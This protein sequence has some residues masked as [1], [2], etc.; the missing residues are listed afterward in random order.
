MAK[1][2][3]NKGEKINHECIE[4]ARKSLNLF[5]EDELH[6][7]VRK[8]SNRTREMELSNRTP[9]LQEA[10]Q[11]VNRSEM[12]FLMTS[13][14]YAANNARKFDLLKNRIKEGSNIYNFLHKVGKSSDYNI[15]NAQRDAMRNLYNEAFGKM[16]KEQMEILLN[17]RHDEE[18]LAYMDGKH[19]ENPEVRAIGDIL[20]TYKEY[21]NGEMI[22]SNALRPEDVLEDR[23]FKSF[24]NQSLV[25]SG[26]ETP[27]SRAKNKF[28]KVNIEQAK[29]YFIDTL[30]PHLN[31]EKTFKNTKAMGLDG[32]LNMSE[33]RKMMGKT[34]DNITTGNDA[35]FTSPVNAADLDKIMKRRHM[36]YHYKDWSSWGQVNRTFGK[37]SL[38]EAW[39]GEI[40]ATGNRVGMSDIMGTAPE[41]L[42]NELKHV[43][44]STREISKTQWG[45][46]NNLFKYQLGS[47]RTSWNPTVANIAASGRALS[48]MARLGMLVVNS[49]S[50]ITQVAGIASRFGEGFW[51]PFFDGIVHSFNLMP[52][53]E[54]QELART[55][56]FGIDKHMGYM[57]TYAD[58][59]SL[60][61]MM[62]KASN[63]FYWLNFSN[64]WDRG[65]KL[66]AATW[67]AKGLGRESHKEMHLLDAQKIYQFDKFNISSAEWDALRSKTQRGLF[68]L[69][70]VDALNNA[71]IRDLWNASNKEVPLSDYR[72]HLSRK[73]FGLFDTVTENAVLDPRSFT[74]MISTGNMQS[75]TYLGEA[76]RMVMQ[77]KSYPI[78]N[79]RRTWMGGMADFDSYQGKLMYAFNLAA[80]NFMLG[81]LAL[82]LNAIAR[83]LTPPNP[84][85]MSRS[86]QFK[87]Y[88]SLLA[89][90]LGIFTKVLDPYNQNPKMAI[91]LLLTPSVRLFTD[92]VATAF[93]IATGNTKGAERTM[94]DFAKVAN[95]IG[96]LP[97]AEHY[98]DSLIGTKPYIEPG[99]RPL[100]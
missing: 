94:K 92:P 15:E 6:D 45:I 26:G 50:D 84:N 69:D 3:V 72:S 7:Y 8:V 71:E 86:E 16:S 60:G 96:T 89:P 9:N 70:N 51:S 58:A 64:A 35:I 34:F 2:K 30:I 17:Q 100:F 33:V 73:I 40:Q 52:S 75:G 57:G 95:P 97:I 13:T 54:R 23:F 43:Q 83:G 87:F 36:F 79:F 37:G 59:T 90:G 85:E 53:I 14:T 47:S 77:F 1:K 20:K 32:Q 5:T 99:Q 29:T 38:N 11:D 56:K 65:Q 93:A 46:S 19:I 68:T 31:L 74:R 55:L 24:Y 48:S 28:K 12:A 42:Y 27:L 66:S 91:D 44:V 25:A 80:G 62:S 49:L 63:T 10:I 61:E 21:S 82:T 39:M 22:R 67:I 98:F 81:S 41:A 78:E 76:V 18:I 88:T 4:A